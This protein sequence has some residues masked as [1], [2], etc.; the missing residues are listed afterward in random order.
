[1]KDTRS[2]ERRLAEVAAAVA[3]WMALGLTLHLSANAYLLAGIPLTAAFQLAVRRRP[4]REL[5]VRDARAFRLGARGCAVAVLL[6]VY[7][8]YEMVRNLR[9]GGAAVVTLWYLAAL[10]GAFPAAWAL[11]C[12]RRETVPTL[13]F[14]LATAGV[15]GVLFLAPA[16]ILNHPARTLAARLNEGCT[17]LIE[18]I[19]VVFML[20][21]VTFR[22]A[23]D[24]HV[25][26]PGERR[27][28]LTAFAVSALWGLWHIPVAS[29]KQ[30]LLLAIPGLIGVHGAI[31]TFFSISWRRSGNLMVPGFVHA[32]IDAVRNAL[33]FA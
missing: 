18:Y 24:S 32:V 29:G 9:S 33:L 25:H 3:L 26:H 19:P 16:V 6:A 31:G 20:E 27:E 8:A 5:W 1:M 15:L 30:P 23:F 17:S 7:P 2:Q 28:Y 10:A 21:E 14:C 11:R 12:F 4:M 13:L 22:G